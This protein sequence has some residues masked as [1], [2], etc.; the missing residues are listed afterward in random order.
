M[1]AWLVTKSH[2]ACLTLSPPSPPS[3]VVVVSIATGCCRPIAGEP[4]RDLPARLAQR[5]HRR[6]PQAHAAHTPPA[7]GAHTPHCCNTHPWCFFPSVCPGRAGVCVHRGCG[8]EHDGRGRAPGATETMA[9]DGRESEAKGDA[10]LR[11]QCIR[12]MEEDIRAIRNE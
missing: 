5:E 6:Q 11:H 7:R 3:P 10:T 1:H 12:V 4:D 8:D 9:L 2:H